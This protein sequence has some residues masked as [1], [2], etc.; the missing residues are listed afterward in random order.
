MTKD[1]DDSRHLGHIQVAEWLRGGCPG[2]DRETTVMLGP[3][4]MP[5]AIAEAIEAGYVQE[6][7]NGA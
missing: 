7:L 5:L 2:L 4:A 3:A 1:R 6:W